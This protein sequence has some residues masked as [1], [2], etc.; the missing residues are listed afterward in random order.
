MLE[1]GG[2]GGEELQMP[3]SIN[4]KERIGAIVIKLGGYIEHQYLINC[5]RIHTTMTS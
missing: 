2:G 1:G 5:S 4:P 3:P